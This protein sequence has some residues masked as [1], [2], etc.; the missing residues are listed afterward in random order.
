MLARQDGE[1]F[2]VDGLCTHYSAP[3]SDGLLVGTTVRC[4]WHH[5][6]FDLRS[7]AALRAPALR[8]LASW[9]VRVEND[10]V[11]ITGPRQDVALPRHAGVV[12]E[13]RGKNVVIVGGGAAGDAAADMLRQQGHT[14]SIV[15]VSD[16]SAPP[17]DRPNLSKDYLAGSAPEDWIPLRSPDYYGEQRIDL[18]TGRRVRRIDRQARRV[19]LDNAASQSYDALIL[20]TG[21][22]PVRLPDSV[23]ADRVHYLR[24]LADSRTIIAA[25]A[26]A[27]RAVVIGASFIGLEVAAAL[28]TRGLDVHVVAPEPHPLERVLGRAMSDFIR[29]THETHGVTFHLERTVASRTAT[30]VK[31]DDGRDVEA[32]LVVAGIGVRPNDQLAQDAG[33]AV[34]RG[35]VVDE[36]LA[37]SDPAIY[38]AGDIARFPDPRTGQAI[39]IEHWVVAQRQGQTA[40]LNILGAR[41]RFDDVPF[42][43]SQHFDATVGYVGHAE[44]WDDIDIDGDIDARDATVTYRKNGRVLAVATLGRDRAGLEAELLLEQAGIPAGMA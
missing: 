39:R 30:G 34:D 23:S 7:G 3:L 9:N 1:F 24:T 4:P 26:S 35:V 38:A 41:Q 17:V 21:A 25:A 33:L 42:F 14:G 32:D 2:A 28:R 10:R 22:S 5:A 37:T 12:G 36:Y 18:I 27:K 20:A 40:A 11:M 16:D 43:W 13:N 8:P 31:L 6:C 29:R 19:E 15:I 44:A